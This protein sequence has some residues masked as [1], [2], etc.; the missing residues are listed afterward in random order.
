MGNNLVNN[1]F[2]E[3]LVHLEH[4]VSV[5]AASLELVVDGNNVV[6][7]GNS[8]RLNYHREFITI[9]DYFSNQKSSKF[10]NHNIKNH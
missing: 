1:D 10:N 5:L 6:V 3:V 9:F 8:R 2:G 4:D 7:N